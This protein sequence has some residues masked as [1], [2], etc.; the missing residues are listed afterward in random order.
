MRPL[1]LTLSAFGP[2]ADETTIDL[3]QLGESGLYLI[4]GDTGA[5]KTTL[6]DAITYALYGEPSGQT[7]KVSM[8]R[9][10]YARDNCP[11]FVE[12]VFEYGGRHYTIRRSP[13]QMRPAKRGEGL[14][15]QPAEAEIHLPDGRLVTKP[16]EVN[17]CIRALLRIDR[18]QFTRVAMIAQGDFLKLLMA[19]TEERK[20][21]F[22]QIF[23]TGLFDRL[24]ERLKQE[25]SGKKARYDEL[26]QGIRFHCQAI[27][28]EEEDGLSLQVLKAREGALQPEQVESLL[29]SLIEKGGDRLTAAE[30]ALAQTEALLAQENRLA[31]LHEQRQRLETALTQG[32]DALKKAEAALPALREQQQKAAGRLPEAQAM[33]DEQ[34]A[35]RALLPRFQQLE[36]QQARLGALT[37]SLKEQ[38][39][40]LEAGNREQEQQSKHLATEREELK[41]LSG[42]PSR[43]V[44]LANH[45]RELQQKAQRISELERLFSAILKKQQELENVQRQ[46]QKASQQAAQDIEQHER[47]S[48]HFLDAQAGILADSLRPGA[49]C[50]VCGALE[51]P[52]PARTA[53]DAPSQQLVQEARKKAEQARQ[54]AARLSEQAHALVSETSRRQE[55]IGGLAAQLDIGD[56]LEGFQQRL[57]RLASQNQETISQQQTL[58]QQ[59]QR[60]DQRRKALEQHIPL[61][62]KALEQSALK[63]TALQSQI[64][65]QAR[66][67]AVLEEGIR[68]ETLQLPFEN[69][70]MAERKIAS[71]DAARQQLVKQAEDSQQALNQQLLEQ[72]G[73]QESAFALK[74]QL[75]SSAPVDMAQVE[76][77]RTSLNAQKTGI[78]QRIRQLNIQQNANRQ[79]LSGIARQQKELSR[80]SRE[81][82]FI[83]NLSDTANGTLQ[84]KDKIMLETYA[85]GFYFD[86]VIR[87]AN[88]RLKTM[89]DG[90]YELRRSLEALDRRSQTGL[91]LMV[92]DHYNGSHREV[93]SLS[94]GESFMAS[95]SLALGLSDEIQSSAGGIR[96]STMFVDE[97]F[98]SLDQNALSQSMKSLHS[99]A[100]SQ[101]LVGIISHVA[102]LKERIEKQV[103]VKK[104][105]GGGSEVRIIPG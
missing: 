47:L 59:E 27:Q 91:D 73:L 96:L 83:K 3:G 66:E 2:Y 104:S 36:A 84:G 51:H 95:L 92:L 21:L 85:Q 12:M 45:I 30:A 78:N 43:L 19:S 14:V 76:A 52:A 101:V 34:A 41:T 81:W 64:A 61:K 103:V 44:E 102:E 35:L 15:N 90:Q 54:Q 18:D 87:R 7:R 10:K 32:Q 100:R 23:S 39:S 31:T 88:L 99:L 8:L 70:L 38:K 55:E 9:S 93:G 67:Q 40:A 71:L 13:D 24:Q 33:A 57:A 17:E 63:L 20:T 37:Q 62:E 11:T 80:V 79:A 89:S 26:N 53:P 5:G 69:R 28:W 72:K 82:A 97:G 46:Y 105:A 4:T 86:R 16:R 65:G 22:R 58:L 1:S 42:A 29:T 6:F 75:E 60:L 49:P 77:R 50:P 74:A 25:A 98:G 48:A 56:G 68:Q 94:G